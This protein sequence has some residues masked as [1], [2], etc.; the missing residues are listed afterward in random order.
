MALT[1]EAGEL[2]AE[3]DY[4]VFGALLGMKGSESTGYLFTGQEFDGE[5]GLY[6]YNARYY[7]PRLGRFI[8]R[9]SYLGQDGSYLSRNRYAYVHN[10]PLRYTDPSGHFL[11]ILG[12]ALIGAV[13]NV[14]I[15]VGASLIT[16]EDIT[17]QSVTASA[18]SGAAG[19]ALIATGVG[20]GAGMAIIA[21]GG[22]ALV[23]NTV[24]QGLNIAS[25]KQENWN[26]GSIVEDTVTGAAAGK[27]SKFVPVKGITAGRNSFEAVTKQIV[28]KLNN[29][30]I[31]KVSTKTV[32]KISGYMLTDG[33]IEKTLQET[34][35]G[36]IGAAIGV[37][38]E[39][40]NDTKK[41]IGDTIQPRYKG[42]IQE[43]I[44][45]NK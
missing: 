3:Y 10:N 28:T 24:E 11:N 41:L 8:S 37:I 22:T 18:V 20:A 2:T 7:N 13:V 40:D 29:N 25:G 14:A 12:G 19:G 26:V 1:N 30:T 16:G 15:D 35:K 43:N 38:G 34:M 27:L 4:D 32:G 44:I 9:D 23:E 36:A 17:W 42:P 5:S 33:A 45:D 21:G 31:S 39:K 6:Y